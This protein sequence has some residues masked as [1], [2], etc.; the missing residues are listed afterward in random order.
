M[1][2]LLSAVIVAVLAAQNPLGDLSVGIRQVEEG[3]FSSAVMSLDGAIQALRA[4]PDPPAADLARGFLYKGVALVGLAQE[5][6]AKAAFREALRHEPSLA[7]SPREFSP[8]VIRVFEAARK[9]R[10]KSV[11]YPPDDTAKKAAGIGALGVAVIATGAVAAGG[12]LAAAASRNPEPPTTTTTT[13][14]TSTTTP[15]GN[16]PPILDFVVRPDPAEGT[17]PFP[18]TIDMC[19]TVDPDPEDRLRLRYRYDW[20]DGT[21]EQQG[22]SQTHTY[23]LDGGFRA[24]GCVTDERSVERC[25]STP[26]RVLP[27][28]APSPQP[29]PSPSPSTTPSYRVGWVRR[30][31]W[32]SSLELPASRGQVVIDGRWVS[33]PGTGRADG[34]IELPDGSG[35][36]RMR[37]EAQLVQA[38]GQGGLWT[39]EFE[40]PDGLSRWAGL[41]PI[42]GTAVRVTAT[43]ITFR[44]EGKPGERVAFAFDAR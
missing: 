12:A 32:T 20:G 39:F 4:A 22:C 31:T 26:V 30:L 37:V 2:G 29:H 43:S 42:A 16:H 1:R 15:P 23:V 3:D 34:V 7:L 19:G 27:R 6:A 44:L 11:L 18:L 24:M 8:R 38:G 9:N 40:A 28:Q 36:K 5:E 33:Y 25:A 17:A 14:T 13:T 21:T 41:R 35:G 10:K